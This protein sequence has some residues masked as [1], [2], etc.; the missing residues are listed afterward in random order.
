M[1]STKLNHQ[2]YSSW[3]PRGVKLLALATSMSVGLAVSE[4]AWATASCSVYGAGYYCDLDHSISSTQAACHL[5]CDLPPPIATNY[6]LTLNTTGTVKGGGT[7]PEGTKVDLVATAAAGSTFAGWSSGCSS[8]MTLTA[9]TTCTATFNKEDSTTPTTTPTT[10]STP[11]LPENMTVFI[12]VDG[13]GSGSVSTDTGLSCK[14]EDCQPNAAGELICQENC[15]QVVKT[16]SD[17]T[18]TPKADANSVFSS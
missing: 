11:P 7:Y 13:S 10:P 12:Q 4:S 15:R 6:T 9:N 17:V 2:L 5:A 1:L 14:R 16:A 8:G 3:F 18:L